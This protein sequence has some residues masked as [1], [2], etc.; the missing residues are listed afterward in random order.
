MRSI[1]VMDI[2]DQFCCVCIEGDPR[3]GS[4]HFPLNTVFVGVCSVLFFCRCVLLRSTTVFDQYNF[5]LWRT[6]RT[7]VL[8]E[9]Q[10]EEEN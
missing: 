6:P 2:F 3:Q 1:A 5:W 7:R 4:R 8:H 9:K 10:K